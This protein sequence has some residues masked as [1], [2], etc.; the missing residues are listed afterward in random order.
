M[1]RLGDITCSDLHMLHGH[2]VDIDID[3]INCAR[4]LRTTSNG[5]IEIAIDRR[6]DLHIRTALQ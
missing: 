4:V 6:K 1:K 5:G 2:C 3:R